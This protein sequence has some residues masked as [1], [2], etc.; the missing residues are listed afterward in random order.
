MGFTNKKGVTV[1]TY[2]KC[3]KESICG[4][5]LHLASKKLADSNLRLEYETEPGVV[6]NYK[7]GGTPHRKM[8]L[9]R[10]GHRTYFFDGG[11]NWDGEINIYWKGGH[12]TYFVNGRNKCGGDTAQY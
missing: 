5:W 9:R 6:K 3:T 1:T 2:A 7:E 12:R 4:L 10:W 8:H 11:N